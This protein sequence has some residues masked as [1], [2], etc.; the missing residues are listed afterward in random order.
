M[1]HSMTMKITGKLLFQLCNIR[2]SQI[3]KNLIKKSFRKNNITEDCNH[4]ELQN[5]KALQQKMS[6]L[7]I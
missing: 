2:T 5:I 3:K 4:K 6:L 1:Y 7:I